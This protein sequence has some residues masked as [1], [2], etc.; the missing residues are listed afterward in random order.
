MRRPRLGASRCADTPNAVTSTA[1]GHAQIAGRNTSAVSTLRSEVPRATAAGPWLATGA[2]RA[3]V[4]RQTRSACT[5]ATQIEPRAVE[6]PSLSNHEEHEDDEG[7]ASPS[8]SS[9]S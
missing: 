6:T 8:W 1:A 2:L 4:H 3:D 9:C 5:P 7:G